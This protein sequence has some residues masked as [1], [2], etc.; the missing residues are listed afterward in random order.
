M[1]ACGVR[2]GHQAGRHGAIFNFVAN[3]FADKDSARSAVALPA[4][5][6]GSLEVLV[7]ANEIEHGRAGCGIGGNIL[8]VKDEIQHL[9]KN[10][11]L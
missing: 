11:Q 5:D 4:A 1:L 6:L 3:E 7:I 8:I 9:N 2:E 10:Y